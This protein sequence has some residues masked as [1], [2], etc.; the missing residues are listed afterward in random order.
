MAHLRYFFNHRRI[1]RAED[2]GPVIATAGMHAQVSSAAKAFRLAVG[3]PLTRL[4]YPAATTDWK[5][6]V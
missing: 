3:H 2:G 4:P 1:L 6:T 5:N